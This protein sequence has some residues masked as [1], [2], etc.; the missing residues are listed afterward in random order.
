MLNQ[1]YTA[2]VLNL[3]D[4]IITYVENISDVLPY[5]SGITQAKT[6]LPRL[7]SFDRPY[8]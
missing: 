8:P 5:L 3:E 7:W 1:D 6:P 4:V 2:K